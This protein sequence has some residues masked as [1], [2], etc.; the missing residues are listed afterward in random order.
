MN[1]A[2][3]FKI[4]DALLDHPAGLHITEL[5]LKVGADANK[6]GRMLRVLATRH[7]F[8]EGMYHYSLERDT[9]P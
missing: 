6:L 4:P 3:E 1:V 7:I 9:Q 8:R 2:V 5:A